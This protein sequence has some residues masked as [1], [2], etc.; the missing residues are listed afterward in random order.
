MFVL[1]RNWP[2]AAHFLRPPHAP[3]ARCSV[4]VFVE[5]VQDDP[6][7]MFYHWWRYFKE[8]YGRAKSSGTLDKISHYLVDRPPNTQFFHYF[9]LLSR[10]C[11]RRTTS[12]PPGTCFCEGGIFEKSLPAFI[13]DSALSASSARRAWC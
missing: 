12:L 1:K 2:H 11:W 5:H 13:V 10:N 4:K 6:A 9:G 3:I 7:T 8:V